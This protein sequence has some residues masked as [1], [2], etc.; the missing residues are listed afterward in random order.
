MTDFTARYLSDYQVSNFSITTV[1]LT[2]ELADTATIVTSTMAIKRENK[3]AK[4]LVLDGEQLKLISLQIDHQD[5]PESY[6]QVSDTQLTLDISADE[7]I[8]TIV[9][10]IDPLNNT[11][12]EGLFKSGGAFCTQC[13]AEGFRR[14]TYY[15]DRP[16]V[17]SIFSTKVIAD[18]K[19]Y[20]Y[21]LSNGNKT[22]AGDL[23]QGK[24]FTC[25][26]DPHPK[27][28]YL[29]AVVAGDFDLLV[30]TFTTQDKRD[31]ALEIFVDKGNL[32]K[33]Q[34]AMASLKKSML[35]DE[36]TFGLVYDLDIYMIVAVDFFN[37][38]A[39][40]NKGLNVFNSKF[41]LADNE[42]ATDTDFFNIEAVIGH[43]YFH[44]WTG[45]RVTCRDWFQLSLKEGLTVF[46][47]QQFSADMHSAAVNRIKNVRL[48]RSKQFAEDAGPMAHP[49]RPEKVLEMNNFYTLTVYEKGAEVIRMINTLLGE[50]K[51]RK[52][53][54]LYFA[55]FDGMA[56]TCDDFI[57][58][59][60]DAS[61]V[62]LDLF[63][64][65][66]YQS[67][68]PTLSVDE[69]F[70]EGQY[71][72]TL[73]QKNP[74]QKD[75]SEGKALHIP[76]AIE[77]IE[78]N[79][80]IRRELLELTTE[81]QTWTFDNL[82]VKPVLAIL[83]DF[84]APVKLTIKQTD[85]ELATIMA[86]ADDEFCRWDAGQQ[87]MLN[88]IKA[89]V[90]DSSFVLPQSLLTT[91]QAIFDANTDNSFKAEQLS[92]PSF[93]E[94]VAEI[95]EVDP[96]KVVNAI[97]A[98]KLFLVTGLTAS[99]EKAFTDNKSFS[100]IYGGKEVGQ[101]ALK[102]VCLSYLSLLEHQKSKVVEQYQSSDN[103]TDTLA[104]L[105]CS[106]D[107]NS[108]DLAG[109]LQH[110]EEKWQSTALVMDKWF[111]IAAQQSS[112][113][114]FSSLGNLLTHPLFSLKNPNR[115]RSLVGSFSVNNPRYFHCQSGQGYQFLAEQIALLNEIN[116]QVASR[117]IT[118]LIQF[119]SFDLSRQELMR[120]EL[121][122]LTTLKNLSKDLKEKLDAA[123]A[124]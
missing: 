27:P 26:Y 99:F 57:N 15:L 61:G 56:V 111:S 80:V 82:A 25:W 60:S 73:T 28:C 9:T 59:M 64:G 96:I 51:F 35:W 3:E 58:A 79:K 11:S 65:W 94:V 17:M 40:E 12:L 6:Y 97:A 90:D 107:N 77:L 14:I 72:L 117:L 81:Q 22:A 13:E 54:D 115:A 88:Y 113:D 78:N 38:G 52:G 85:K 118:P 91:Y 2:F 5:L 121:E 109:Q 100:Y 70:S 63:K 39:M 104:A 48:L 10:E 114:I 4:Q 102:N 84:S 30:D 37:M 16:D 92:L 42:S 120:A 124:S 74:N 87:L 55:R 122:K 93:D 8:L 106:A 69:L 68:T 21:L 45:N 105:V 119:R 49:I 32:P 103:M 24:H 71:Q 29:F 75:G 44:N 62:D 89:L 123:L 18:K 36:E 41:V 33:A 31:V 95:A 19:R 1:D 20:P 116:P 67:G 108:A 76:V 101:R 112:A 43:E 7:F 34:H 66:Y 98:V 23:P 50:V 83:A 110:F 53:M 47:D 86:F 46:R